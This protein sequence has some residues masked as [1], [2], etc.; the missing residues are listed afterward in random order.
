M[1]TKYLNWVVLV[2]AVL[3]VLHSLCTWTSEE[4]SFEECHQIGNCK[5]CQATPGCVF[6]LNLR[7]CVLQN[8][9]E[10]ACGR[11]FAHDMLSERLPVIDIPCVCQEL[12][13][14]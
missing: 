10:D 1:G 4:R 9:E 7:K 11:G 6:C 13:S 2:V 3:L 12:T 14:I 8:K 5:A